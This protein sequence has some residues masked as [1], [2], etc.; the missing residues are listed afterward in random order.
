MQI[1]RCSFPELETMTG[2]EQ[3]RDEYAEE[4][5]IEG[6]PEPIPHLDSYRAMDNSGIITVFAALEGHLTV[7]FAIVLCS[8]LPHYSKAVAHLESFFVRKDYRK[9]GAG[10]ALYA[11]CRTRA[12]EIGAVAFMASAKVGSGMQMF[13]KSKKRCQITHEI[14][15]E[16]FDE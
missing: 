8:V 9:T 5:R 4:S 11:E 6:F 15:T 16:V 1:V 12:Q 3:V 7:G 2:I 14:F 13:M 10:H